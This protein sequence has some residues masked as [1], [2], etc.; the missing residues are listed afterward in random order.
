M[1]GIIIICSFTLAY[2]IIMRTPWRDPKTADLVTGRRTLNEAEI[3][4]LDAYYS[5]PRW[6]RFGTYVQ[7]WEVA[8]GCGGGL[9]YLHV[10]FSIL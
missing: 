7:L 6:R 2:K 3:S 4:Q 8:Y 5:M 9:G 10:I 1:I